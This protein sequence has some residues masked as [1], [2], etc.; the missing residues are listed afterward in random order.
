M[1]YNNKYKTGGYTFDG[2]TFISG[3]L[4]TSGS[5]LNIKLC[6]NFSVYFNQEPE[7]AQGK[8]EWP[9]DFSPSTRIPGDWTPRGLWRTFHRIR[10]EHITFPAHNLD[11]R[12]LFSTDC[13]IL[14]SSPSPCFLCTRSAVFEGFGAHGL[15][16][17]HPS[18]FLPILRHKLV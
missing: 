7:N 5:Q 6:N 1:S 16:H 13:L 2:F 18:S 3:R 8:F 10:L 17:R 15:T 12:I 4:F 9:N 11:K 14:S